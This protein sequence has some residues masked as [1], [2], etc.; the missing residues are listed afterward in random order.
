V[1]SP[2][3]TFLGFTIGL[4]SFLLGCTTVVVALG[5]IYLIYRILR[6]SEE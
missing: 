2:T 6:K 1:D 3:F 4:G 5:L